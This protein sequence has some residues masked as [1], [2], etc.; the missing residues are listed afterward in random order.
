MTQDSSG[1][2]RG[3]RRLISAF[4]DRLGP[5]P[6]GLPVPFGD[7]MAAIA[8]D[9]QKWLWT[10]DMLMD[11]VDF[12][13]AKHAWRQVG[14]KA[15]AVN[16]SD[17]AAMGS[18][19]VSALCAVALNDGL[20]ME[21]AIALFDGLRE[22]GAE[23]GCRVMGGDTNS[24]TFPTVIAVTVIGEVRDGP[25]VRR[26]GARP[27]DRVFVS[28]PLGGSI[29]GRHLHP[30]P[31]IELGRLL[32]HAPRAN[33][34]LDI[35][36]GLVLDLSRICEA[37][38]CGAVLDAAQ[39]QSI[40]H[41]DAG[42]LAQLD[43]RSALEHALYDGEDFELLVCLP[44]EVAPPPELYLVGE[45]RSESGIALRISAGNFQ[46]LEIRGWEHFR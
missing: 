18:S 19:P 4:R 20:S 11:G 29:L 42:R 22:Q 30:V 1:Q 40:C 46:P 21:A 3:E 33:A 32:T 41:A 10:T 35:S 8:A 27:G 43:G 6:T 45:I 26:D 9:R 36:D 34:M 23:W 16:L 31:R 5:E 14:R 13:S 7:D 24:W 38:A 37:S 25:P 44:P 2:P 12:D 39:I 15:M 17:C 28:G